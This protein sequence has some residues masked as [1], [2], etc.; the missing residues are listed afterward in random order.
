VPRS[1]AAGLEVRHGVQLLPPP[2]TVAPGL[3]IGARGQRLARRAAFGAAVLL[4]AVAG[5]LTA[6]RSV[7][8]DHIYPGVYV[9]RVALGGSDLGAARA[10]LQ[11]RAAEV[12]GGTI[13]VSY[14]GMTWTPTLREVGVTIDVE[15]SLDRAYDVGREVNAR[16]RLLAMGGLLRHDRRLPLV[17]TFDQNVLNSWLD[18][19]D[20]QL[21]RPPHDASLAID[22]TEVSIVPEVDGTVVDRAAIQNLVYNAARTLQ[23]VN[24]PLPVVAR[25]ANVRAADLEPA[26][27]QVKAMLARPVKATFED[28]TW[29]F[30]PAA[31]G[32]FLTQSIDPTKTG[33]AAFT[34]GVDEA[35]LSKWLSKQVAADVNRDPVNAEVAWSDDRGELV[36]MSPSANGYKLKPRT[37]AESVAASLLGDHATVKVPVVTIKPDVDS[38]NLGALGITTRLAVGDS[39]YEGSNEGRA[40]N[41]QVGSRL[42]NGTLIPPHGEFS[43]NHAIGVIDKDKGYV[44]APVI[45]GERIGRDVGGGICQVS[46]TVFRAALKAGM[47]ITEWWPHTYRLGFYE[48]DGWAPGFDASILQPEGDPFGGGDFKFENPSDA[49]MLVESYTQNDRVYVILYG[50]DLGYTVDITNMRV[51]DPIPPPKDDLEIV[52]A[53]LPAGTIEQ[54]ELA[55]DGLEVVYDRVVSDRDGTVLLQDTWD[56][57]FASRPNV[58]KVSPDMKGKS[59]ASRQE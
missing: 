24:A 48:Q 1:H 10:A 25:I 30:D 43:F 46:T 3:R 34:I 59:P 49:W 5:A 29:T 39:N 7:Y 17:V 4:L 2:S 21:G 22:G 33:A 14:G 8:A 53:E 42:L 38:N 51:S 27:A 58:W 15:R 45:D 31:L 47:P 57:T 28:K 18:G 23:P 16:D 6:M 44:D 20:A 55:Q 50:A 37:F 52:D 12:E 13:T 11:Q 56:T 36:A 32:A 41:I 54:T 26:R 40:T 19:V 35:A 9:E